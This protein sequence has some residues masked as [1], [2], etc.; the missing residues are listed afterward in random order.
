MRCRQLTDLPFHLAAPLIQ[1]DSA[2]TER[3][4]DTRTQ[5]ALVLKVI[6]CVGHLD[7][8]RV[9]DGAVGQEFGQIR[10]PCW[11]R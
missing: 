4:Q 3:L 2:W 5:T 1:A 7:F 6:L 9:H 10:R 8:R 11:M